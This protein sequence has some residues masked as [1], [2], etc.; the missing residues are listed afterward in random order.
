MILR[1]KKKKKRRKK[2][3][4]WLRFL[5]WRVAEIYTWSLFV[6][7]V[8]SDSLRISILKDNGNGLTARLV[9]QKGTFWLRESFNNFG[10]K[11]DQHI[12]IDDF[13]FPLHCQDPCSADHQPR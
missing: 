9:F 11:S 6:Y 3:I 13:S 5:G 10:T 2:T 1:K 4:V 7:L 12:D 8:C